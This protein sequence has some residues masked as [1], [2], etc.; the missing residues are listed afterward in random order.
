M[1]VPKRKMG[2]RLRMVPSTVVDRKFGVALLQKTIERLRSGE[3]EGIII[4]ETF[5][6]D[7]HGYKFGWSSI[8]NRFEM[9]GILEEL[10]HQLLAEHAHTE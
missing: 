3:T 2:R 8:R 5:P 7:P 1:A 9:L 10:K 6:G 4:V